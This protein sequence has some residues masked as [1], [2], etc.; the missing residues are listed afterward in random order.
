[1]KKIKL[2]R[3]TKTDNYTVGELRCVRWKAVVFVCQT[4]ELPNKNNARQIS[5][6][7]AGKY[8]VRKHNSPKFKECLKVFDIDGKSEVKGRSDILIHA[9]NYI[10]MT[11]GGITKTDTLG[12][13]LPCADTHEDACGY[14]VQGYNSKAQLKKLLEFVGNDEVEM[15]IV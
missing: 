14:G 12:C 9:G 10:N 1:M 8:I 15:E 13:I 11:I 4:I 3:T 6:I 5:C 2:R 7:P